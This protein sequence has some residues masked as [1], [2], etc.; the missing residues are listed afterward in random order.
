M[1][2]GIIDKRISKPECVPVSVTLTHCVFMRFI[3]EKKTQ[4]KTNKQLK[5]TVCHA[6]SFELLQVNC[7]ILCVLLVFFLLF[8]FFHVVKMFD[9]L[10]G[11]EK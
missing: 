11:K 2:I 3:V 1:M 8:F 4:N 9:A 6:F 7:C 10:L 5:T